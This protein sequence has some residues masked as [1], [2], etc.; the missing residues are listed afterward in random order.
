MKCEKYVAEDNMEISVIV[1]VFN[2]EDNLLTLFERI[3]KTLEKINKSSEVIFVND[4]SND[5]SFD[6]LMSIY[7]RKKDIVKII[8]FEKNYGQHQAILAGFS[9]SSGNLQ[10]TI[11]ADL[12][13]PPE[14]IEK[15]YRQFEKEHDYIGTIRK[16][17]NDTFFRVCTS[18]IINKIRRFITK[19]PITDQ[20]C[21]LRGYSKNISTQIIKNASNSAFIPI[22]A[23]S[24]AKKPIEITVLHSQ[25]HSGKSKYNVFSLA[26]LSLNLFKKQQS[27]NTMRPYKI[28]ELIGF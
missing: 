21:M 28:K 1:P 11:D 3:N 22:L 24:F 20:G 15:I 10:I 17:R 26:K 7:E 8:N 4:G 27:A 19:I 14:E 9:K 2:E 18:K 12:Q 16:D 25:R 23:Y 6:V 13:N 5:S